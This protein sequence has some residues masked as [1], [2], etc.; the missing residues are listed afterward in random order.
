MCPRG[1]HY[2]NIDDTCRRD[3][4]YYY[5]NYLENYYH[6]GEA[7]AHAQRYKAVGAPNKMWKFPY[8]SDL[9]KYYYSDTALKNPEETTLCHGIFPQSRQ[10]SALSNP[11]VLVICV[12]VINL[13]HV[14]AFMST[15]RPYKHVDMPL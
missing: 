13:A 9:K 6:Y 4:E 7:K 15:G 3:R 10:I 5:H 12:C 14:C 2:H 1:C 11:N 8:Y